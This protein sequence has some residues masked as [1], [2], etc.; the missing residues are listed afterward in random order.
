MSIP[1]TTAIGRVQPRYC[2]EYNSSLNYEKL[3][4]VLYDGRPITGRLLVLNV[5][6]PFNDFSTKESITLTGESSLTIISS[7]VNSN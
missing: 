2:G 7:D 3:D 4:N 5:I 6:C 1:I